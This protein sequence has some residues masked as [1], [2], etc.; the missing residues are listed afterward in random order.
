MLAHRQARRTARGRRHPQ[1]RAAI[2]A[3]GSAAL[4]G[5]VAAGALAVEADVLA[6]DATES[7]SDALDLTISTAR[8]DDHPTVRV[9][10]DVPSVIAAEVDADAFTL[11]E[12]G[13]VRDIEVER[14]R[15]EDLEVILLLDSSG[16]MA[17]VPIAAAR[18][19]ALRFTDSMPPTVPLS[20]IRFSTEVEQLTEFSTDREQITD[21]IDE[22]S[23]GGWTSMYDG[24]QA[25]LDVLEEREATR[26][27]IVLLS[28]GGDNRSQSTLEDTVDRLAGGDEVLTIVE[29]ITAERPVP[30]Q[31]F[32]R[33]DPQADEI[34]LATL[35]T[36]AEAAG[37]GSVLS[38]DDLDALTEVYEDIAATLLN[39]YEL[40]YDSE[41]FDAA[42]LEVRFEQGDVVAVGGRTID[43]PPAPEDEEETTEEPEPEPEPTE[44]DEPDEAE[45]APPGPPPEP[46]ATGWWTEPWAFRAS[47]IVFAVGV[48]GWLLYSHGWRLA[49][50]MN[51]R[52]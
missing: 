37:Q 48:A 20:V 28:D 9:T 31:R 42:D 27:A 14:L 30:R 32:G 4:L 15:S 35:A 24:L 6:Q 7:P 5:S 18:E 1:W 33:D 51:D 17:G 44:P 23:A 52:Y 13:E 45:A 21:A 19:A 49:D 50:R 43:L 39:Q 8:A 40:T 26:E 29:L 11:T 34:D 25:A 38:P 41:A 2:A 46:P 22:L 3:I 10:V 47:L 36:M 12:N 16:S